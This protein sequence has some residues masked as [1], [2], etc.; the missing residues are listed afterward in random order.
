MRLSMQHVRVV[1]RIVMVLLAI[2]AVIDLYRLFNPH[3]TN[4]IFTVI[5]FLSPVALIS[6][7]VLVLKYR[8]NLKKKLHDQQQKLFSKN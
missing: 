5:L 8:K 1:Y 3:V 2:C 7:V 4:V 6:Y